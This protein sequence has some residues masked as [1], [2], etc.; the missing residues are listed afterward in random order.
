M[1]NGKTSKRSHTF[2]GIIPI[3]QRR[4]RETDSSMVRD[5]LSKY[6]AQQK[7]LGCSGERLNEAARNVFICGRNL[8]SITRISIR[9]A[10]HFF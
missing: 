2:E 9:E 7:C 3:M 5:E 10:L 8:P 6:L 4:Y 1:N